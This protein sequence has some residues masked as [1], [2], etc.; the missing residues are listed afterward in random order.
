MRVCECVCVSAASS[1]VSRR[2]SEAPIRLFYN[3]KADKRAI[4]RKHTHR[5]TNTHTHTYGSER[6]R[7]TETHST[8]THDD[9]PQHGSAL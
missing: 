9:D 5:R 6:E 3:M 4:P 1:T 8:T 7:E 2:A